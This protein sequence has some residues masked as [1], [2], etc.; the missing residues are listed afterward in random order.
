M[1]I[2]I[3]FWLNTVIQRLS[4]GL[5]G[6]GIVALFPAEVIYLSAIQSM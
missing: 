6:L 3:V 1:L 5:Y 4:R 2:A